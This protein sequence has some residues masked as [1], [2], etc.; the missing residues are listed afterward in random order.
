MKLL[1]VWVLEVKRTTFS[2]GLGITQALAY[3]LGN[4]DRDKTTFGILTS[5]E[6]FIFIKLVKQEPPLYG[7]SNKL[8]KV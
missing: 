8:V 6:D 2:L 1:W 5:G 3:M 7:L 4:P